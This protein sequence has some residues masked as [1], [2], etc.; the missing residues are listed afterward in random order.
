[1]SV[2]MERFG[3]SSGT[4]EARAADSLG[5]RAADEL[6]GRTVWCVV[7]LP[8]R[9]ASAETLRDSLSSHEGV[10]VGRLEVT[11][12]EPLQALAQRLERLLGAGLPVPAWLRSG[13]RETYDQEVA[14]AEAF[15]AAGIRPDDVAV[16]HDA[17]TAALAPALRGRGVHVVW[18]I[19]GQPALDGEAGDV[20]ASSLPSIDAFLT[21]WREPQG[22]VG[23]V[24]AMIPAS[25]TVATKDV[26]LGYD[27]LA[28]A[29]ALADVVHSDRD[30]T[31]GGT[32]R[33]RPAV[34]AR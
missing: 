7:A 25:G 28:W 24:A 23:H 27:G 5:R 19:S 22:P 12:A 11:A 8:E 1:M 32:L 14:G 21:G 33:A 6:G 2:E 10:T 17:L 9:M 3:L 34:A 31:V 26:G 18:R 30:D 13:D 29:S 20:M 16:L 4:R 15:L